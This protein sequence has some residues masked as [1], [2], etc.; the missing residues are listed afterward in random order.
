MASIQISDLRPA[1]SELFMDSECFL[2]EMSSGEL[3]VVSGGSTPWCVIG[4]AFAAGAAYG[5]GKY[6][7]GWVTRRLLG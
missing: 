3:D 4:S 5:A 1:G 6:V 7:S 2:S